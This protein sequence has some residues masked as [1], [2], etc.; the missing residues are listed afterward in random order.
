MNIRMNE[1]KKKIVSQ[2]IILSLALILLIAAFFVSS[3]YAP[4]QIEVA[5][6]LMGIC[7][8]ITGLL[9][10]IKPFKFIHIRS[11]RS[12][13][14]ISVSGFLVFLVSMTWPAST[15]RSSRPHQRIDDFMPE[16]QFYEYHEVAVNAPVEEVASAI[17]KVTFADIPVAIWLMRI[18]AMASGQLKG[19][20]SSGAKPVP[21]ML[22]KPILELLSQ[23]GSA[24]LTLDDS[25]PNEYVGGMVGKPWS[26]EI[27]THVS[28]PD[29]F[30]TF[31]LPGNIKVAFNMH[32]VDI[33]NGTSRLTTETRIIGI[34]ESARKT[35]TR[36]WR[37]IY[38]GSAI[39]RRV[40]LDAIAKRAAQ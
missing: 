28:S 38:P 1:N 39:I 13:I 20:S 36:Y 3:H 31:R 7:I 23:P 32:V 2:R 17:K 15:I 25:D 18:R 16:Y 27:P 10:V 29:E 30:R 33:G 11:R 34:D 12:A 40:W 14:L 24:F 26:S 5:G 35:F 8:F 9:S 4:F 37:V 22:S 19:P 21:E 6:V